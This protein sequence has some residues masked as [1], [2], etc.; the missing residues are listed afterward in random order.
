MRKK[1]FLI[2]HYF[3]VITL[4][5]YGNSYTQDS[6]EKGF[7]CFSMLVGKNASVD[8]SVMFAH[9]EDDSGEQLVNYYKVQ[10]VK[11]KLGGKIIAKNG[12]EIPQVEETNSYFWFEMP[13]M[14]F[15]D[16]YI[17]EWGVA[18]AS[19]QCT[20]REKD[21][22]LKDGGITY[23][24]RR[25]VAERAKSA[26]QGVKIAG[27][28]I[29][30]YGYASC[31][32][33]YVI[34]DQNEGWML[35]VV[36]G[37]HWVAKR[38]P[39]DHVAVIP[40][41]YTIGEINLADTTNYLGAA[42]IVEYAITKGWYDPDHDGKFHFARA[43]SDSGTL[44]SKGNIHRMWRGVN[45]IAGKNFAIN[46][47]FPFSLKPEKKISLQDLMKVMRDHYEGT[48]LDNSQNYEKGNPYKL[49]RSTIC[50]G[51]NK[52][53]FI[54]QLR[55]WLPL[56]IGTV[57]WL[58]Q[59][60]TDSQPFIPWYFGISKIPDGF[61]YGNYE[62]ALKK[63]FDPPEFYYEKTHEHAFWA[64]VKL[65]EWVDDDY[66]NR[67]KKVQKKRDELETKVVNNQIQFEKRV[68]KLYSES[69]QAV[70]NMLTIYSSELA[71]K[72]LKIAKEFTN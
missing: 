2:P 48:K 8:G 25:L 32:R 22:E 1:R 53:S 66:I 35:A 4:F 58:A 50:A 37:K 62:L 29:E 61:A 59:R 39:D 68:I 24:L 43:Y 69:P 27:K 13:K 28:L 72:T 56:E 19:D 70:K 65:A 57:V 11:H 15:S 26:K 20:S 49:N 30:E 64:F 9:N 17:N 33:T 51:S 16:S 42:D 46:D 52:Y 31:G 6:I 67:I 71:E 12:A 41:Y 55:S 10:R 45:L 63:H 14:E 34:A 40:N 54:A 21:G 36:N 7:N 23:W 3:I 47:S 60:R 38:V 44:K 5:F 18:I